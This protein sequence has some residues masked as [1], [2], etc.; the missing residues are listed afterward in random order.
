MPTVKCT[1]IQSCP[2]ALV[3]LGEFGFDCSQESLLAV[4]GGNIRMLGI[5]KQT[6]SLLSYCSGPTTCIL[7]TVL[8]DPH[9]SHMY[10][11]V[12]RTDIHTPSQ[13]LELF[14]IR[15]QKLGS[16][17]HPNSRA[18]LTT[19]EPSEKHS[20]LQSQIDLSELCTFSILHRAN[21]RNLKTYSKHSGILLLLPTYIVQY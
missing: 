4:L 18:L 7:I 15:V 8:L 13:W 3:W 20:T 1:T 19:F 10:Y 6:P 5:A 21:V 9:S 17:L 2:K 11:S 14:L 16:A 12:P